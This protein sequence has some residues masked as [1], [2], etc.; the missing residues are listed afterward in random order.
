VEKRTRFIVL[1]LLAFAVILT[2]SGCMGGWFTPKQQASLIV[3]EAVASGWKWE[4]IVSVVNM[5]DGGLAAIEIDE[6]GITLSQIDA[7]TVSAT[8]LNGFLL[9]IDDYT[10]PLPKGYLVA[11]NAATG[12]ESGP[13]LK[14]SFDATG[15]NPEVILDK[16]KIELLSDAFTWITDWDF[17]TKAYYAE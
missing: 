12:N 10:D 7:A 6:D 2:L 17:G 15:A 16:A 11:A 4:V 13:I 9:V 3:G 14:F 1:S 5:P 8:G